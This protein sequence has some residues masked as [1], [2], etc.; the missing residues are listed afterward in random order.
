MLLL[1]T[2]S[3]KR[4]HLCLDCPH[5]I[6]YLNRRRRSDY[7]YLNININKYL[8]QVQTSKMHLTK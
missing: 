3:K 6:P 8:Q 7:K 1:Q 5:D 2:E 4:T